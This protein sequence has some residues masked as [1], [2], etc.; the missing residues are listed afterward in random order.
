VWEEKKRLAG[1]NFV[2]KI[3]KPADLKLPIINFNLI[4]INSFGK[5]DFD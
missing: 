3:S 5:L 4:L 2:L 1:E